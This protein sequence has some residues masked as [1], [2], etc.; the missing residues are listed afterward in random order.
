MAEKFW[1]EKYNSLKEFYENG[2]VFD[3]KTGRYQYDP[4][5][6]QF[7][8]YELEIDPTET[9]DDVELYDVQRQQK[10][11]IKCCNSFSYFCHKYYVHYLGACHK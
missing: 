4:E 10:E 9:L 3:K 7:D 6:Y 8:K 1:L 11:I 2:G 5:Y